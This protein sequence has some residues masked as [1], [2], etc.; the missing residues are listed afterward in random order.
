MTQT[1]QEFQHR[2]RHDRAFRQRVLA[3]SKAGNLAETLAQE[4]CEYDLSW[5][6]LPLPLVRTGLRGGQ[7]YCM[8]SPGES[9]TE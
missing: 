7:C 5:L 3:A 2:M 8:I 1:L 6:N 9:H 4:G